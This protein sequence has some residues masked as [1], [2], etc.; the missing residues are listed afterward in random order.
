MAAVTET[1]VFGEELET[2]DPW[3]GRFD[4]D[5]DEEDGADSDWDDEGDDWDDEDEDWEDDDEDWEDDDEEWS[6]DDALD[7]GDE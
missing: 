6:D 4:D 3:V 5:A 2:L 7:D 1:P